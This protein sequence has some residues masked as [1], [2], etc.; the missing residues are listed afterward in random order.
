MVSR[1]GHDVLLGEDETGRRAVV[2]LLPDAVGSAARERFRRDVRLASGAPPWFAAPVLDAD[3]DADPPWIATAHVPGPTLARYVGEHGTLNGDGVFALATRM[4]DGLVALHAAGVTHHNIDPGTVLLADD[5]PRLTDTGI[6]GLPG[7][8]GHRAPEADDPAAGP[9]ADMYALGALLV[10]STTGRAPAPDARGELDLGSLTGRVRD[11]A[12]GCLQVDWA[13]RPTA[14]QLREYLRAGVVESAPPAPA[15]RPA[16]LVAAAAHRDA[17]RTPA[18]VARPLDD[19]VIARHEPPSGGRNAR[20][21]VPGV[22]I[23][24]AIVLVIALVAGGMLLF[25]GR[26]GTGSGTAA[27]T[28]TAAPRTGAPATA[29]PRPSGSAEDPAAGAVVTDAAADPRFTAGVARFV[30]PS[31]NITCSLTAAEA[32][33]DAVERDWPESPPPASCGAGAQEVTG[34]ALAD[35]RSRLVCGPVP[36]AGRVVLDYGTGLRLGDVVCV[37]RDSGMQCQAA[38]GGGFRIN[39]ARYTLF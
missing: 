1:L 29:D 30:S 17:A 19:A 20:R 23:G 11:G 31:R 34:T 27:P 10:Y 3:P 37:S 24:A 12:L 18:P 32:R 13:Q 6:T 4:L 26:G 16:D 14:A 36:D 22:A 2:R 9:P 35:S 15:E 8:P 28:A 21:R 39:R 38:S 5:G 7:T 33:C 25:G